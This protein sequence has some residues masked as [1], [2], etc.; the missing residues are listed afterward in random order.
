MSTILNEQLA[1]AI[2]ALEEI[3]DIDV[4][5]NVSA[6]KIANNALIDIK[7]VRRMNLDA[8]LD[9]V[10]DFNFVEHLLGQED[11]E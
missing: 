11:D 1:L 8:D 9:Q 4:V 10:G 6:R 7:E 3:A 2:D 5:D